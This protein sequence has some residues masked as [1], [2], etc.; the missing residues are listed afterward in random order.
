MT[1]RTPALAVRG[2]S[3]L[4]CLNAALQDSVRAWETNL[5]LTTLKQLAGRL[6]EYFQMQVIKR[7][8]LGGHESRNSRIGASFELE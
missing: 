5:P 3:F 4:R 2:C 6:G 1:N 8:I 7:A